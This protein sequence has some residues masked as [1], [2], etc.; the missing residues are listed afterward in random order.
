MGNI[1]L[2]LRYAFRLLARQPVFTFLA[3][4]TLA[5]GIGANSAIFAVVNAVLLRPLPFRDPG[6]LVL[7]EEIINKLSPRGM[8][9]TPSDLMEFQRSS[10]AF[11]S[12]AGYTLTAMDLTGIG[13]PERL[14]GL[15]VSAEIFPVLGVSPVLGRGFT[16]AEDHPDSRVAVI[17][18][19]LWQRRFAGDPNIAGRIVDFDRTPTTILGVLPKDVEFPLPGLPFGGG[20]DVWVPLGITPKERALIGNYNFVVIARLKAGISMAEARADVQAVA[21]RIYESIPAFARVGF[22]LDAQLSPVTERVAHD[23]RKLLWLLAGAVGFVLLIACVNVANLLLGRAAGREKELAIRSSLGASSARLLRQLLTESL[24]LSIGGGAA[25]LLLAIW[26]VAMLGRVI[27]ASVPRAATIDTDWHVVAFTAIVSVLAGLLFGTIP[28]VMAGRTD[29]SARLK[30]ASQSATAGLGRMRLR[31]LLVMSEVALSLVLLVGAGLLVRSLVALRSVDPGFDVQHILTADVTLPETAY[32]DLAS[33][34]GFFEHA[35]DEFERLPGA[36]AAGA[37]T[38]PLLAL[39]NQRLFTLKDPTIPSALA[40]NATV[41]GHYFQA[42]GIRLLRGRLFDSR[43]RRGSAPVLVIN[44]AMARQYFPGKEAIGQQIKLGSP[45][46]P[47]PWYTVIGV[48]ADVKNNEL[49]NEIRPQLYQ[50]YSQIEDPMFGL[51]FGRSMILAVKATSEPA[52]LTSAVRKTIARLDPELPVSNLETA[53]AQVEASLAPEWFQTGLV[54][55][56]AGLALLLAAIGIYGVVS[57][58]VTQRTREIGVRVALGASRRGV[59]GLVIGQGMKS[60]FA[61]LLL[62]IAASLALTRLMSGFLF[63]VPPTDWVT[64]SVAPVVLCL[65]ALAANLAPARRAASV[66]P[67]I[68]LHY[69]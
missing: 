62:G 55:C 59:L 68:A 16:R 10:R 53:R 43:D 49:A 36:T 21:R 58:A 64:F 63:N 60:V 41:L 33:V 13:P 6:R 52:A 45:S 37:A 11:E 42:V 32:P 57:L 12:V 9:V 50:T 19:R 14:E 47:D 69:E 8:A 5:L 65:V 7:I 3:L 18:Y 1:L 2:D 23:T 27:P 40:I 54:A 46:S 26:L 39:R 35:V 20:H 51:G 4:M 44:E 66:D 17:S 48:V 56:F 61:G 28:A 34:R 15:R 30:N 25:G 67:M 24:L 29:E 31:A 38:S 22:T